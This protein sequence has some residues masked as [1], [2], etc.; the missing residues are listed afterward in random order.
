VYEA[1]EEGVA[2]GVRAKVSMRD[3]A[4]GLSADGFDDATIEAFDESVGLWPIGSGEA[5]F[6]ATF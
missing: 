5:V 2:I 4:F 1:T 3:A 6:D